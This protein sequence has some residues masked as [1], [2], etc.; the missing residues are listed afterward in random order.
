MS[1][2]RLL[3]RIALTVVGISLTSNATRLRA[4]ATA[5]GAA[6]TVTILAALF[7]SP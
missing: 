2:V 3:R 7:L 1:L 6:A 4:F 5:F